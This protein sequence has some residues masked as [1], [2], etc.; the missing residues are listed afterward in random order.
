MPCDPCARG[1]ALAITAP[2]L[3][4]VVGFEHDTPTLLAGVE[5]VA[6]ELRVYPF[7]FGSG[8]TDPVWT[9]PLP[10]ADVR[11]VAGTFT[12]TGGLSVAAVA[13]ATGDYELYAVADGRLVGSGNL[14]TAP[15]ASAR[16]YPGAGE[17]GILLVGAGPSVQLVADLDAPSPLSAPLPV[18]PGAPFEVALIDVDESGRA[19]VVVYGEASGPVAILSG[20]AVPAF[21][22]VEHLPVQAVAVTGVTAVGGAQDL[23]VSD[24]DGLV[25]FGLTPLGWQL[26]SSLPQP[27]IIGLAGGAGFLKA[28]DADGDILE[29][30]A[31]PSGVILGVTDPPRCPCDEPAEWT[32][33]GD[34][35]RWVCPAL[36][37]LECPEL[38][39]P[40]G[41]ILMGG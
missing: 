1:T 25:R 27:D 30:F 33:E 19:E 4:E 18:T 39:A 26:V 21:A 14:G 16:R 11:L 31:D 29:L 38:C 3:D 6:G 17:D 32:C 20:D 7:V 37:C 34:S 24:G 36:S 13:P 8:V 2:E 41:F 22:S 40:V 5:P 23:V 28:I 9:R 15:F 12:A 10:F 35:C